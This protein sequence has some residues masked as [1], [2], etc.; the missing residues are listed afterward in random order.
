MLFVG[1]ITTITASRTTL[2][3]AYSAALPFPPGIVKTELDVTNKQS[4]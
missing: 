2:T 4:Q 3:A 1:T